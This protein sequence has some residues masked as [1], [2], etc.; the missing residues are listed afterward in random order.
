MAADVLQTYLNNRLLEDIGSDDS[1]LERLRDAAGDLADVLRQDPGKAFA[2]AIV[3]LDPRT[4]ASDPTFGGIGDTL[5]ARWRTYSNCFPGTPVTVFRAMILTA[6]SAV[7]EDDARIA[8]ALVSRNLLPHLRLGIEAGAIQPV[9]DAAERSARDAVGREWGLGVDV[10]DPA[11]L[12]MSEIRPGDPPKTR[13]GSLQ[14]SIE[15]AVGPTNSKGE[16]SGTKPNP[17]WPNSPEAWAY[18]FAPR[19]ASAVAGAIDAGLGSMRREATDATAAF[20]AAIEAYVEASVERVSGLARA[21]AMKTDL[22]WWRQAMYSAGVDS[23][24]RSLPLAEAAPQMA[25]DLHRQVPLFHP[26]SVEHFLRE[27]VAEV[28]NGP[29]RKKPLFELVRAVGQYEP[30]R[31]RIAAEAPLAADGGRGPLVTLLR[32]A[33]AAGADAAAVEEATGIDGAAQITLAD[34]A[35]IVFRELQAC[36]ALRSDPS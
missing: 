25:L 1:R 22:L 20:S 11:E 15:A 7:S 32:D 17:N 13:A 19:L 12:D 21:S 27:S 8:F 23:S 30:L 31:A 6:L 34:L 10:P 2:W 3:A 16:A 26:A 36:A 14:A 33:R 29:L 18:E 35:V 28:S 4:P 24:Y 5:A 9:V